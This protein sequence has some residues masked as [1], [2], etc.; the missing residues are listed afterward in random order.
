LPLASG[1]GALL[2]TA[3]YI[4]ERWLAATNY[5][6]SPSPIK[7]KN[8]GRLS[9]LRD[10]PWQCGHKKGKATTLLGKSQQNIA[11]VRYR[12]R[13]AKSSLLAVIGGFLLATRLLSSVS[14]TK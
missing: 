10:S 7:S 13:I 4:A 8:V 9:T 2:R 12:F 3:P 14:C 11:I 6:R 5:S 1:Q